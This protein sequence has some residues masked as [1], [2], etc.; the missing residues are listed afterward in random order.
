VQAPTVYT[1]KAF[2]G[3]RC[4]AADNVVVN[5]TPY[6]IANA[7]N[8]TTICYNT[9]AQL[10]GSTD[11]TFVG[12]SPPNGLSNPASLTTTARLRTTATYV[13]TTVNGL[14]CVTHDTVTVKVNPQV[15]A[16]AGRDTAIVVGQILQ[17][18]GTGGANYVW[19]PP[20][21]LDNPHIQNP[22]GVYDGS[23]D[24]IRYSLTVTDTTGCGDEA[25]V[26]VKIFKTNPRIFVP[27]AFTPNGDGKNEFVAPI[28]VGISKIDY[29]RVYNRWGQMVFETSVNGKG[30]DGR[31]GGQPQATGTYVWIVQGT[32]YLGKVV[33]DKGTV[34]LIR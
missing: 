21:G 22:K 16:S 32:D 8:D 1:V 13:L 5:L 4:F 26:L 33:F 23:F 28:A 12:W 27:T 17:L 30:W 18:H 29:F 6:S 3:P 14:G 34:T 9:V 7:G 31:L 19:T 11:G 10:S 2:I 20:T 25:T 24:S 15:I